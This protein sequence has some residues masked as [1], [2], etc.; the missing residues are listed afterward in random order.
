MQHFLQRAATLIALTHLL[1]NT[2]AVADSSSAFSASSTAIGSLSTSVEKSS[3]SSSGKK[4]VA[5]G[6]YTLVAME[7]I[8]LQPD[9]LRLRLV[10]ATPEA[11]AEISLRLPRS[12]VDQAQLAVGQTLAANH[13]P[14]GVAFSKVTTGGEASTFFLVLADNWFGE[15]ESRP[16][17]L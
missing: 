13:R 6:R 15:L 9:T 8:E 3:D 1:L 16:V 12:A 5:Q 14:Y 11:T 17:L 7:P 4:Q 10:A 2:A